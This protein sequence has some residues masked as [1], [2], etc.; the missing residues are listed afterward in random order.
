MK[1]TFAIVLAAVAA[2]ALFGGLVYAVLVAAHVSEPAA[3]TVYGLTPR[4]LWATSV[5]VLALVGV[6]I[7]G[8]SLARPASRFGTPSGRLGAIVAL[9]AGLIAVI[10]G[11]LNLAIATGG[12]GTGNG[13]VGGAAAF[14]LGLIGVAIGGLALARCRRTALE[15][16]RMT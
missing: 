15:P 13:V 1:R 5:A 7:G 4:R 9:G 10:N 6:V 14:V 8:L 2:V 16:G 11:G 12:P 3:T